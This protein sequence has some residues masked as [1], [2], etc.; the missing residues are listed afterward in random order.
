MSDSVKVEYNH[1]ITCDVGVDRHFTKLEW[2]DICSGAW[3]KIEHLTK[4]D[5]NRFTDVTFYKSLNKLEKRYV[6]Y[7][8]LYQRIVWPWE[9]ALKIKF[10]TLPLEK[11]NNFIWIAE[12]VD[13]YFGVLFQLESNI[14]SKKKQFKIDILILA[15]RIWAAGYGFIRNEGRKQVGDDVLEIIKKVIDKHWSRRLI[16][17]SIILEKEK[18][19]PVKK[20]IIAR[21]VPKPKIELENNQ[22]K[23]LFSKYD[24]ELAKS[25]HDFIYDYLLPHVKDLDMKA[26]PQKVSQTSNIRTSIKLIT[27]ATWVSE[28]NLLRSYVKLFYSFGINSPAELITGGIEKV[29]II[30]NRKWSRKKI[31]NF[32]Y[33][34]RKW[35]TYYIENNNLNLVVNTVIPSVMRRQ[36]REF[37]KI[38]NLGNAYTLIE[39]LLDEQSPYINENDLL[40]FRCRR[41]C[42]IQLATGSR[43]TAVCLLFKDC[44]TTDHNGDKW[45]HLHKTKNGKPQVVR[46]TADVQNWINQ[47]SKVAPKEKV[48]SPKN[49]NYYGD[50]LTDYRLFANT[51]DIATLTSNL[52][53][54]FLVKIQKRLWPDTPLNEYF[55][56][57]DFRRMHAIYMVMNKKSKHEIQDQLGHSSPNSL[58]PYIATST[59]E[60]QQYYSEIY[61]EGV[62]SNVLNKQEEPTD[63]ELDPLL[64]QASKV[65]QT[66]NKEQFI[67]SLIEK[68]KDE[69]AEFGF[70][71]DASFMPINNVSAGF[72]RFTHNCVAHEMLNCGHTELHCFKCN[73]YKPD[74]DKYNEHIA[75]IFRFMLLALRG[76]EMAKS[77]R[78]SIQKELVSIRSHDIIELIDESFPKLLEKK[79]SIT[80]REIPKLKKGLWDKA[81]SYWKK[82]KQTKPILTFEEALHY[83]K[84]GNLE[85][86]GKEALQ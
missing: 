73:Y 76:E 33:V 67:S 10:F 66:E 9:D 19:S 21:G 46:A 45:L 83:L 80:P 81:K 16:K 41:V 5:L 27:F 38:L 64:E 86:V 8:L 53:G 65:V 31:K 62:W 71:N 2:K 20:R 4:V 54:N 26:L 84:V 70:T 44:I 47:S 49:N 28:S 85:W 43:V 63:L 37:G 69:E 78:D 3:G 17:L 58:I 34:L 6:N 29:I 56:S 82:H 36:S 75:E 55:T 39:T 23:I 72:P 42:L 15:F 40:E 13:I 12:K 11:V 30:I 61:K 59:P 52:I 1:S 74:D 57:H 22:W 68:F 51:T 24:S 18:E 48:Y 7:L 35:L 50:G 60:I 79:F 14:E 25:F 32:R 77:K